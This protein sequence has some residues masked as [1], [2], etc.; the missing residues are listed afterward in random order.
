MTGDLGD[1]LRRRR[2]VR[3][4]EDALRTNDAL[5]DL[6]RELRRRAQAQLNAGRPDLAQPF[7]DEALMFEGATQEH[8]V[9]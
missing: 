4:H 9:S 3:R 5:Y 8:L 1:L 7:I 2:A 6:S